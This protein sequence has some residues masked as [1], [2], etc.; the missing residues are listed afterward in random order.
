M[1]SKAKVEV[2]EKKKFE[3]LKR[4]KKRLTICSRETLTYLIRWCGLEQ[5]LRDGDLQK[6]NY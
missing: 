2:A 6:G 3:K 5:K 1:Q 4:L